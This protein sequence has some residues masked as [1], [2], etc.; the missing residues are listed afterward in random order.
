MT[1]F[2]HVILRILTSFSHVSQTFVLYHISSARN[3]SLY[4]TQ[5][6][7]LNYRGSY[8]KYDQHNQLSPQRRRHDWI[9]YLFPLGF[10]LIFVFTQSLAGL[11][12]S[13]LII[14]LIW[15][16]LAASSSG[17][18]KQQTPFMQPPTASF[19]GPQAVRPYQ[20]GYLGVQDAGGLARAVPRGPGVSDEGDR[21]AQ[22]QL[23]G[24][25]YQNGVL[26]ED[27]FIRQ[28]RQILQDNVVKEATEPEAAPSMAFELEY[29]EQPPAP[30]LKNTPRTSK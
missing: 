25:L 28:K 6:S 11:F 3:G 8:M 17:S 21:L 7:I 15:A 26:S 12:T 10:L 27:E 18:R 24:E 1:G 4:N 29:D 30:T 13:L 14:A 2:G 5:Q 22:L 20:E 9:T 16:L 23:L 19:Y